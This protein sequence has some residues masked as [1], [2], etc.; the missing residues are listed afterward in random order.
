[1]AISQIVTE[2]QLDSWVRGNAS[3]AQ[4]KIV[5]LLWRLV[6]AS[7]PSPTYRRFPLGD[8]IG[9]HGADGELETAIDF[10]PFVP[11]GNSIWEVGTNVDARAKANRDYNDSTRD[12]PEEVRQKTTFIFVTPLSGRRDW[13]DTWKPE[14]VETWR[15]DKR[16]LNEWKDIRVLDGTLLTDWVSQFPAVGH[17]LG[18]TIGQLPEDFDTVEY[19]WQIISAF[20]EPPPLIPDLFTKG[21]QEACEKVKR[22][23]V[24]QNDTQLR[25]DTRFPQHPK[26]FVSAYIA[27]LSEKERL[28]HQNRVLIFNSEE[29][30][31]KAC[32]LNESHVFIADFNL[33]SESGPQLIQRALRRRHAVIYSTAPGGSPHGNACELLNPTTYEMKEALVQAGYTDERARSLT[34]RS[35]RNLNALLRLIQNLSAHPEW[36]TQSEASD[37]AI[38]QLIGQWNDESEGDQEAIENL[39]GK[40]YGEWIIKIRKAASVKSTPLQFFNGRWKFTSRYEPWLYLSKLIGPEVIKRFEKLSITVLSEIDP[41]LDLPKDQRHASSIF[42]KGQRY[43]NHIRKGFAETLALLGSHGESLTACPNGM[44]K[45]V[46]YQVVNSLLAEAD[47]RQWASLNDVLP[48]FAEASP[49]AF[50]SA[51]GGASEKPEEPFSGVFAEEGD[52]FF[53]SSYITGLLWA[54]ELLAWSGDYL[55]RVCSILANL[56]SVDPG[57]RWAN[58]PANSLATILLPWIP[59]T[60]ADS[61]KRHSAVQLIVREH[62]EVAWKLLLGLLPQRHSTSSGTYRPKW[63]NFIPED[64]KDGATWEQR[65]RDE[66]FYA[67]IALKLAGDSPTRL[68]ELLPFYFHLHPKYSNFAES[69][70]NRLESDAIL[71]LSDN[72]RLELWTALS[73]KITN[74]K[75]YKDSE[76]WM[77]PEESLNDLIVTA[78]KLKPEEPEVRHKRLF[79][80]R[81]SDLYNEKGN[82]EEQRNR[83]LQRRIDAI[84]EMLNRGGFESLKKFWRSVKSPHEVGNA[85][86]FVADQPDDLSVLPEMLESGIEADLKF[87]ISYIWRRFHINQWDWVDSMDRSSW[88]VSAKAEFFSALPFENEVWK[89]IVAE[90]GEKEPEYWK[91]ARAHP[92][93]N[94]LDRIEYAI[95]QL[96]RTGRSDAAIQCFWIGRLWGDKFNEL[97]LRA[98]ETFNDN[99]H[100]DSHSIQEV[101]DHLQKDKTVNEERL[102]NM[103]V[104]FLGLLDKYSGSQPRTLYRHLAE[105]SKFFCEVIRMI[106]RSK[107]EV[108]EESDIKPETDE[109]AQRIAERAYRLLMDWDHPP[110]LLIDGT[111]DGKQLHK[112][113]N[114]VKEECLET[115][116]WEIASQKIGEVLFHVP[117][118]EDG[119]W[120]EPACELLDS[121]ENQNFRLG[122]EVKIFN[123]RGTY[124][125]S[126]GE[127][128]IKLAEKWEEI[129]DQADKKGFSRLATTLRGLGKSYREDAKRSVLEHRHRFD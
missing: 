28:D 46:V 63:H 53:G 126:G 114:S 49:D 34:N 81:D 118:D 86:G 15:S 107:K 17:W 93:R 3:I 33:D 8:S 62:P 72:Q 26:D 129:A 98:L 80:G 44:P 101:I 35:G 11:E 88:S 99:H 12:T 108:K 58:R 57:G 82:W 60:V 75:K 41:R 71:S 27:S 36:A 45:Q 51:V 121:K 84:Q 31:K 4:G 19:Y 79:S 100:V 37:I 25:L 112:W 30:F 69:L 39:S 10:N 48:L 113:T 103:E 111:F 90:L 2:N 83:L 120:A 123:S 127:E 115:G 77:V 18:E 78:N 66:A 40:I 23:I 68:I 73:T 106:F 55:I 56:A 54:L 13:K 29:A 43:S 1:M 128:E 105:R 119:L 117:Q 91:R 64:W 50:L 7:C 70:L 74:H 47:S 110:G 20:G 85:Y 87:S 24:E 96:I 14:G 125:F 76:A 32:S 67:D 92:D 65:W 22:L 21:R 122:L 42:G 6:C 95:D 104:K 61:E 116:H 5:E 16:A 89:R 38:A 52:A 109:T 124:G 94:H 9:Q 97:C 102:A 59:R